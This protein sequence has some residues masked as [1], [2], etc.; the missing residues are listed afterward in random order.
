MKRKIILVVLLGILISSMAF[1]ADSYIVQSVNKAKK[2][3]S[4]GKW[5]AVTKDSSLSPS[6][7]LDIG[8]GGSLVVKLD[9]KVFTIKAMQKGTLESLI[10]DSSA[11]GIKS[12]E[13][14]LRPILLQT[15]GQL[16][17]Q[18]PHPPVQQMP[19]RWNGLKNKTIFRLD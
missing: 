12:A 5:E 3:V 7:V 6:T 8:I 14:L 4:P 2:E 18:Q 9:D 11:G 1:A 16:Q 17:G 10:S 15:P 19:T 13:K